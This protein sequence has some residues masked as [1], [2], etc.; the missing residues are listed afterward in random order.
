MKR[1]TI[2]FYHHNDNNNI[3]RYFALLLLLSSF[4]ILISVSCV[5]GARQDRQKTTNM[6]AK[7]GS[8]AVFNCYID[9]PYDLPIPYVVH[10]S[11]DVS[12]SC[13]FK[14][15]KIFLIIYMHLYIFICTQ[16]K[17]RF[18]FKFKF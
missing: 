15:K 11:K 7:V 4:I 10:W 8:Y 5:S 1:K 13:E 18:F 16:F 3:S 17:L 2:I 6:E 12:S 9:F 14:A